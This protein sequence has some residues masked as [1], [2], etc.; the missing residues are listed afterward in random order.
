MGDNGYKSAKPCNKEYDKK[1]IGVVSN[2]PAIIMGKI[3][4]KNK[5]IVAMNGVVKVKVTNNNGNIKQGD[6]LVS[7]NIQGYAMKSTK[8]IIGTVLGKALEDSKEYKDEI[9]ALINLQ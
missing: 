9:M 4:N 3:K 6:L 5:A 2:N 8:N 1:I 7:S